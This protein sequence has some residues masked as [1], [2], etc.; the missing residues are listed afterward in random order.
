MSD[1]VE[2]KTESVLPK[3]KA[4]WGQKVGMTQIFGAVGQIIPVTVVLVPPASVTE[5]LTPAKHG[6]S[7]VR[8]AFG[9]VRETSLNKPRLGI[10]KKVSLP[11]A[12]W[13]REI[14]VVNTEGYAVGQTFKADVFS[15]GDYVDVAGTSKGRGFAGAMKRHNFRGG[16]ATHGQ[17]DRARAPGSS[18][19]NTYPGRVFKGKRFPGHFG[20]ESTTV[21]HLEVVGIRPE[22]NLLLVKGALPGPSRSLVY[23]RETKKHIKVKVAHVVE[24]KAKAGKKEAAKPGAAA[25]AKA[26]AAK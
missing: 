26:K 8:V 16:P 21:Q 10:F 5:V 15:P 22:Q 13:I 14:R 20:V 2:T 9:A 4:L 7:A 6:Y 18:G 24:A 19:A 11:V 12:R 17:S 25:P 23:I 1:A 3:I